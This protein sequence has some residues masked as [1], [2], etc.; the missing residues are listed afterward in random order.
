MQKSERDGLKYY[1]INS[2]P[3]TGSTVK[4]ILSRQVKPDGGR[5]RTKT[6]PVCDRESSC[7]YRCEYCDA[8]LV[9]QDA[10]GEDE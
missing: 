8:D 5:E 1:V 10:E 3:A 4:Q 2:S 9:G 7:G 6:C